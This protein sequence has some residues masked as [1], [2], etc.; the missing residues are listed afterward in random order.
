M[1]SPPPISSSQKNVDEGRETTVN[2]LR[3]KWDY[4]VDKGRK[5]PMKEKTLHM[6]STEG[7]E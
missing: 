3:E 1:K 2:T 7:G 4:A 6:P 5:M